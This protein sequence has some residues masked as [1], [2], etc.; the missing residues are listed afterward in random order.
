[1]LNMCCGMMISI[2]GDM[3][4]TAHQVFTREEIKGFVSEL[5]KALGRAHIQNPA[6]DTEAQP[7]KRDNETEERRASIDRNIL[8]G[9]LARE[10]RQRVKAVARD[11]TATNED[12]VTALG[13]IPP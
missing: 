7:L 12:L 5:M 6:A 3:T 8:R 13:G 1:M 10:K 4:L 2:G 9:E 11:P